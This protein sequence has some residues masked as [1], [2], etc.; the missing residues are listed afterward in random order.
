RTTYGNSPTWKKAE[1][2]DKPHEIYPSDEPEWQTWSSR[3]ISDAT[4]EFLDDHARR[5]KPQPFYVNVWFNDPH[6]PMKPTDAMRTPYADVKEPEQTHYAM[7]SFM[8]EQIGRILNKLDTLGLRENT[9]VLFASDNG[10]VLNRGS[11]NGR[12]RGEKW[13]IYEGG[14]RVQFI[15]RWPG[16]V[17]AG[18]VDETSV[19]NVCDLTPTFCQLASAVMPAGYQSDGVDAGDALRGKPFRRVVPMLWYHPTGRE[20]SPTLAIRDGDWKLMM[21]PDGARLALYNLANDVSEKLDVAAENQEVVE[22]LK[23][24]LLAWYQSLPKQADR[25]SIRK[26]GVEK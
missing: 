14:I 16:Q 1:P 18:R 26:S 6:T 9:L 2:V 13:T 8:D 22:R 20:K 4:I 11:S 25:A 3:A 17:P 5:H 7:V 23:T 24:R 10:G 12:L 15:A 19:L 21:D